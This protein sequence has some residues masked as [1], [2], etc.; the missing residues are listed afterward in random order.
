MLN[1]IVRRATK[2]VD[3]LRLSPTA[4]AVRA[5]RLTYLSNEKLIRLEQCLK[6][7][8]SKTPEGDYLEF[9]V[10]LGGSAIII[11]KA[12]N[13]A[14]RR[15]AGFDVFAMI[16]PPTSDKD[17]AHSKARYEVIAGGKSQGIGGDQYYGYRDDLYGDVVKAFSSNGIEVDQKQVCLVKGLF[18]EAWP[19]HAAKSVAFAHI[20]CDWYDPVHYCL[21]VVAPLLVVGGVI[22]L[23]D[24]HDYGGCRT[25][26]DEFLKGRTDIRFEDGRNVILRRIA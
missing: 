23:D 10:A 2:F 12:A 17:D 19:G 11:G 1:K 14:G 22:L 4:R 8:K 16:P 26:T 18:E 6:D 13:E 9:G 20:D 21:A 7:A 24:Y 25:A 5:Q 15:F 3:D